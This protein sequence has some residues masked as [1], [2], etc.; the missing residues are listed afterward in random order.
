MKLEKEMVASVLVIAFLLSIFLVNNPNITGY[1]V[2]DEASDAL[3]NAMLNFNEL[4]SKNIEFLNVFGIELNTA[5]LREF[6]TRLES[7]KDN[8]SESD[9]P[10][11]IEIQQ[12]ISDFLDPLPK[13]IK[14]TGAF[15]DIQV[16]ELKDIKNSYN[17]GSEQELYIYQK[18]ANVIFEATRYEVEFYSGS[19]GSY[20][21]IK[22]IIKSSPKIKDVKIYEIF[23]VGSDAVSIYGNSYTKE[24]NSA[25]YDLSELSDYEILYGIKQEIDLNKAYDFKTIIVPKNKIINDENKASEDYLCGDNMCTSPF[26]DKITCPEDCIT[27]GKDIPWLYI[28]IVL[29]IFATGI[30][31]LNLY[32]GGA[33]YRKITKGK[34]PFAS[35]VD[36]ENVKKFIKDSINK[37]I[38]LSEISRSLTNKGWSK[39]Q[40]KY[41]FEDARW[42]L[43]KVLLDLTPKSNATNTALAEEYI[44]KC[45]AAGMDDLNIKTALFSRG[46]KPDQIDATL[47]KARAGK[48][49]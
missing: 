18:N 47:K 28:L 39:K 1:T 40:I 49:N 15:R 33:D 19:K 8:D 11:I 35:N 2:L 12:E 30:F 37:G 4:N 45:I 5:K 42:E 10:A 14:K 32:K 31:Y 25:I 24:G 7:M 36:L 9:D 34:S 21:T 38:R 41:A 17:F 29:A 27:I 16:L 22:K 48:N 20:T 46:W 26:E 43:R 13:S 3:D 23:A 44:R 6:K